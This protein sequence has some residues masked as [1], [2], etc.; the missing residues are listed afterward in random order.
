MTKLSADDPSLIVVI[1]TIN[2]DGAPPSTHADF[3]TPTVSIYRSIVVEPRLSTHT[4][5]SL[6][7]C[8]REK[9]TMANLQLH[10]TMCKLTNYMYMYT[11]VTYSFMIQCVS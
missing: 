11:I 6:I 5:G 9:Y 10:D 8:G 2:T 4:R 3:N 7:C 1:G